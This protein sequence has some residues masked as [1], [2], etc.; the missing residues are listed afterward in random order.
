M[1]QWI[2]WTPSTEAESISLTRQ[3]MNTVDRLESIIW[4]VLLAQT[5]QQDKPVERITS[6]LILWL[7]KLNDMLDR[8]C[9]RIQI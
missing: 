3:A 4:P 6:D 2:V 1:Q 8:L 7:Q 5:P 9:I